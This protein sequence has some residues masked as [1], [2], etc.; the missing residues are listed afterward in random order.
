[1]LTLLRI[2]ADTTVAPNLSDP[3]TYLS[4]LPLVSF[5]AAIL[6]VFVVRPLQ[7]AAETQSADRKAEVVAA[8][9]V[10]AAANAEVRRLN[11]EQ[12]QRDRD[13]LNQLVPRIQQTVST[14][15]ATSQGLEALKQSPTDELMTQLKVL[16]DE[17][18]DLKAARD[19]K[20]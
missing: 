14:L 19:G 9:S 4:Q 6:V 15:Q 20:V 3:L 11:D 2:L 17:V 1:M 13:L 5:V 16:A 7:K 8:A 12:K 18:R 10:L